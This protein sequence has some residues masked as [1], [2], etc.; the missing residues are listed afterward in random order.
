MNKKDMIII[1]DIINKRMN[2]IDI[3]EIGKDECPKNFITICE[4]NNDIMKYIKS[5]PNSEKY[6]NLK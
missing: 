2:E 6:F 4:L 3:D 1:A 5:L